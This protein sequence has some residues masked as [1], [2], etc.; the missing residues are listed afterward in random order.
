M[1]LSDI[2]TGTNMT[3]TLEDGRELPCVFDG[4]IDHISFYAQCYEIF[5]NLDDYVGQT[6]SF[7]FYVQDK[8]FTFTGEILAK[9][10]SKHSM[11]DTFDVLIKTPI[12]EGTDRKEFRLE[13]NM[14]VRVFEYSDDWKNR[15]AGHWVCDAISSDVSKRGMRLFTDQNL[16]DQKDNLFTLEFRLKRDEMYYMQA[17]LIRVQPNSVTRSYNYDL[18]FIFD[19]SKDPDKEDKFITDLLYAKINKVI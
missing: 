11:V 2:N 5:S 14:K 16:R 8:Y 9:G 19:F 17:R 18:G 10:A 6:P 4:K 7:K 15:H 1:Y 12:K 13:T 3:I